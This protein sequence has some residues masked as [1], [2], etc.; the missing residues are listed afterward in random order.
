VQLHHAGMRTPPELVA[1]HTPV[2][3]SCSSAEESGGA[4]ARALSTAEV[5]QL[6]ED[7]VA[8]AERAQRAVRSSHPS[9][10]P[11]D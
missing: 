2:A 6:I 8:G 9:S 7:F 1:P 10:R 4:A 5:E 11:T 3:P